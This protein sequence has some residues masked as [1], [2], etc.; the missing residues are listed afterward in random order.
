LSAGNEAHEAQ[1]WNAT[2]EP[3]DLAA[4]LDRQVGEAVADYVER[5]YIT[6]NG[7]EKSVSDQPLAWQVVFYAGEGSDEDPCCRMPLAELL[8]W[9]IYDNLTFS[10]RRFTEEDAPRFR[11]L[12]DLLRERAD[13]IDRRLPPAKEAAA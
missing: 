4:W 7:C 10:D 9:E 13:D 6:L 12:R 2:E 3:P 11:E 5:G 1:W 8:D